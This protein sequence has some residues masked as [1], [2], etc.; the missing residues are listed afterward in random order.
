MV[1]IGAS[2]YA[3]ILLTTFIVKLLSTTGQNYSIEIA[4]CT[5][6]IKTIKLELKPVVTMPMRKKLQTTSQTS[7]WTTIQNVL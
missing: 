3:K 1:A 2:W 4:S 6:G 7:L 5:L